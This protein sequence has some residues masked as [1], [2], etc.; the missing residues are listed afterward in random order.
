MTLPSFVKFRSPPYVGKQNLQ[1]AENARTNPWL[2]SFHRG[3]RQEEKS[4]FFFLHLRGVDKIRLRREFRLKSQTARMEI[5]K[6][7]LEW[8]L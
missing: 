3:E 2:P 8:S 5:S 1:V 7:F 4:L 6:K